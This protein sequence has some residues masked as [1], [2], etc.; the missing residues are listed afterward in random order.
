MLRFLEQALAAAHT[1]SAAAWFGALVYR[2]FFVDP[3]ALRLFIRPADFERFT[4]HLAHNMRYVLLAA[5]LTCGLSGLAL[6]GLR[7]RPDDPAWQALMA[8][9]AAV[10]SAAFALFAYVSWVY[11]PRRLFAAEVE[12]LAFRRQ[13][14]GISLV[15]I[16]LV[17]LGVLL[18]QAGRSF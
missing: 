15:M 12:F 3:K 14:F 4:L 2:T 13:G 9:K 17:G 6:L 5:L 16:G 10:W 1:L 8:G 7:W 11:W 18:G